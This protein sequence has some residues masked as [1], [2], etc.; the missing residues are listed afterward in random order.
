[1]HPLLPFIFIA[2]AFGDEPTALECAESHI[3]DHYADGWSLRTVRPVRFTSDRPTD[4][5]VTVYAGNSYRFFA[6]GSADTHSMTLT[7]LRDGQAV[8]V[9]N[10]KSVLEI[11]HVPDK[12]EVLT[13]RVQVRRTDSE[14]TVAL[15]VA[16]K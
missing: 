10:G 6:C 4:I 3:W 7:L 14:T 5:E 11:P 13:V 12:N 2:S 9:Q 15:G 8:S 16:L 1:V